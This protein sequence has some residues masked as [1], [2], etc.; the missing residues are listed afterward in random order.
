MHNLQVHSNFFSF[1]SFTCI[2][3]HRRTRVWTS[4][5]IIFTSIGVSVLSKSSPTEC[6]WNYCNCMLD[7]RLLKDKTWTSQLD[8]TFEV[9]L[10]WKGE[11]NI[12]NYYIYQSTNNT[13]YVWSNV[14]LSLF[15]NSLT[16]LQVNNIL[17]RRTIS[18][19]FAVIYG[20]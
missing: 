9:P 20:K 4:N 5:S 1:T 11:L 17:E 7:L 15:V 18:N 8:D 10:S 12:T 19:V 2:L 13:K 14:R 3:Q 16:F 6:K